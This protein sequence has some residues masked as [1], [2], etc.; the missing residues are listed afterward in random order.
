M[1]R[2]VVRTTHFFNCTQ[3]CSFSTETVDVTSWFLL[4]PTL[5]ACPELNSNKLYEILFKCEDVYK[6]I[7][8]IPGY[9]RKYITITL[10]CAS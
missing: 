1:R 4:E 7:N 10:Y 6:D 3:P 2:D 5:I 8:S 9:K